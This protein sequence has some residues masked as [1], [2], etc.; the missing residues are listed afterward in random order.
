MKG[1]KGESR[2]FHPGALS[3]TGIGWL[4]N[5]ETDRYICS[6]FAGTLLGFDD[7]VSMW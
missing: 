4:Q 3:P 6:E 1:D 7:Y 2:L 5:L